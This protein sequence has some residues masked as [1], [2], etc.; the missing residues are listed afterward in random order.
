MRALLGV[1]LPIAI[2]NVLGI[3]YLRILVILMSLL[4]ASEAEVGNYVTST[5]VVEL[6]AGLPFLLVSVVLPVQA[7]AALHDPERV[8]Y[9]TARMT[10]TMAVGGILVA[11]FVSFAAD[12]IIR[13]L[14]GDEYAGAVPVL[15]IQCLAIVTIFLAAAWN[16][17]IVALGHAKALVATTGTG[18]VVVLVAGV[19]LIPRHDAQG[20]AVAAAL[21]D[22]ALCIATYVALR[23]ASPDTQLAGGRLAR[24]AARGG[25]RDRRR[26]RARRARRG[27]RGRRL[28]GLRRRG[29][30]VEGGARRAARRRPRAASAPLG[31]LALERLVAAPDRVALLQL[32]QHHRAQ[33]RANGWKI[34]SMIPGMPSR[35]PVRRT[36]RRPNSSARTRDEAQRRHARGALLVEVARLEPPVADRLDQVLLDRAVREVPALTAAA[37]RCGRAARRCPRARG[38]A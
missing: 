17:A 12:P 36:M 27:E 1:A 24:I 7:V 38:P 8:R 10:E 20:A 37:R 19:V 5:R 32:P 16:P 4:A 25:A 34:A 14:G 18:V 13:I 26:P 15:Q 6:V 22:L 30:R 35:Q 11:L 29:A 3:M 28:R 21:A 9:I 2:A 23:R 33:K 31:D